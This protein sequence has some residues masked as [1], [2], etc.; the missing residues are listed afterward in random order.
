M[1]EQYYKT[2]H[3]S[4]TSLRQPMS[5]Q[6]M[7]CDTFLPTVNINNY[8]KSSKSQRQD[9]LVTIPK[10]PSSFLPL[11]GHLVYVPIHHH[12]LMIKSVLSNCVCI[13]FV[14]ST[15]KTHRSMV[16]TKVKQPPTKNL[17]VSFTNLLCTSTKF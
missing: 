5:K 11:L 10:L 4:Q 17:D 16:E 13:L 8:C 9:Q 1:C 12:H 3:R 6:F 14:S 15:K 7:L 2:V